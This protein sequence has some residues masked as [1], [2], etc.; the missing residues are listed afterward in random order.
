MSDRRITVITG[1]SSGIG[2]AAAKLFS[3]KGD[4]VY[5][6]SRRPCPENGVI[7]ISCDITDEA[8]VNL[9]LIHI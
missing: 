1:A 3:E 9:S 8:S 7:S 6:F 4:K 5:C 2:L